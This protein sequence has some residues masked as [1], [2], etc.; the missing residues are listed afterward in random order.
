[1]LKNQHIRRGANHFGLNCKQSLCLCFL[2]AG[3]YD[4]DPLDGHDSLY[5]ASELEAL[6]SLSVDHSAAES[7]ERGERLHREELTVQVGNPL[8][9]HHPKERLPLLQL[10]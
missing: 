5:T 1:M 6:S 8:L 4:E 9:I 2:S 10:Q 3:D 7:L